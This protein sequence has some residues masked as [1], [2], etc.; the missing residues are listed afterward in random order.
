MSP[1]AC[2]FEWKLD[3]TGHVAFFFLFLPLLLYYSTRMPFLAFVWGSSI[4]FAVPARPDWSPAGGHQKKTVNC[5]LR[6]LALYNL[7]ADNVGSSCSSKNRLVFS[8]KSPPQQIASVQ[9]RVSL[10]TSALGTDSQPAE[11]SIIR[12][13]EHSQVGKG[14]IY[15]SS[16]SRDLCLAYDSRRILI[17]YQYN[18]I[19]VSRR[20]PSS[21]G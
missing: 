10:E 1:S 11:T 14:S 12:L 4:L 9:L 20:E 19:S 6:F 16:I 21:C 3:A 2:P 15:I 5:L 8:Q 7:M 13:Y 18:L 17:L